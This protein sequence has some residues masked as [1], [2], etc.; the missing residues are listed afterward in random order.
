MYY[1]FKQLIPL[2]YLRI[3][4]ILTAYLSF[5]VLKLKGTNYLKRTQKRDN[6]N[7]LRKK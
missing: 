6:I 7:E 1:Y 4:Y 2:V 5:A 3:E